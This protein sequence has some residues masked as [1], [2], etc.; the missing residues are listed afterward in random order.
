MRWRAVIL[1]VALV[2]A[3]CTH[4]SAVPSAKAADPCARPWP[5]WAAYADT[6]IDVD[7]KVVDR[8][9]HHVTSEGQA[10]ALVHALAADDVARF[11]KVLAWTEVNLAGGDLTKRLPAWQWGPVGGGGTSVPGVLDAH[12]ASDADLWM[13]WSLAQAGRV[14]SDAGLVAKAR[15]LLARIGAEEVAE[16]EGLGKV[17]LPGPVGFVL[18]GP[19]WRLNPS[20]VPV[21]LLRWAAA[22]DPKGP[23]GEVLASALVLVE[24]GAGEAGVAP[25]WVVWDGA[26]FAVDPLRGP[27]GSYDAIRV[28][29]WAAMMPATDPAR[30]RVLAATKGFLLATELLG[31][32]PEKLDTRASPEAQSATLTDGPVGF[33]AVGQLLAVAHGDL[34]TATML[35][36]RVETEK[37]GEGSARGLFGEPAFY[38]DQNLVLF[39][40]AA[41][42]GRWRFGADGGFERPSEA[43]CR[44]D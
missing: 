15:A 5:L 39:A 16:A 44:R 43:S 42:E 11:R 7:G 28:Y 33:Q 1:A 22:F 14:W 38:Y 20:Y 6:F 21:S 26:K 19:A 34:A 24:K 2:S 30:A 9:A 3:G 18:P 41:L 36:V 40:Q 17:L 27:L 29:L 23:W 10:Y 32:V 8:A 37:R 12:A 4:F 31:A 35:A 13:A 25:D